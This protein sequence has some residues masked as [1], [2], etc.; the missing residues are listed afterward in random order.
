MATGRIGRLVQASYERQTAWAARAS[1]A[2]ASL[3]AVPAQYPPGSRVKCSNIAARPELPRPLQAPVRCAA[4]ARSVEFAAMAVLRRHGPV[5]WSSPR[6]LDPPGSPGPWNAGQRIAPRNLGSPEVPLPPDVVRK[7]AGRVSPRMGSLRA[8]QRGA[9]PAAATRP[10]SIRT[11]GPHRTRHV[12]PGRRAGVIGRVKPA[13]HQ[14]GNL[15]SGR[16]G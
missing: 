13:S 8:S 1:R 7:S 9:V 11:V 3:A 2:L 12:R 10:G 15:N 4:G 16:Q 5:P 6:S 14:A